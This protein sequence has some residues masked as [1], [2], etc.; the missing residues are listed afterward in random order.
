MCVLWFA[1]FF[2]HF[3]KKSINQRDQRNLDGLTRLKSV[4]IKFNIVNEGISSF[5]LQKATYI[6]SHTLHAVISL[7]DVC[8]FAVPEEHGIGA[9]E[10]PR[11]LKIRECFYYTQLW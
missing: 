4:M 3:T 2:H 5:T 8:L 10:F 9:V 1:D 11:Q 6:I 7:L